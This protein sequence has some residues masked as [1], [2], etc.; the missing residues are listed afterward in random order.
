MRRFYCLVKAEVP[1][2][3]LL[4]KSLFGLNDS[5]V[6]IVDLFKTRSSS[7]LV[8]LNVI[9]LPLIAQSSADSCP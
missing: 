8:M 2:A 1:S 7:A 9:D 4:T 6:L 3:L 5:I